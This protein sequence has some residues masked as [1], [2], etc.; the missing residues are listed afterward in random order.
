MAGVTDRPF[1]QLCRKLSAGMVVSEMVAPDSR[2][3]R[4]NRSVKRTDHAGE[5][6]P[7]SVQIVGADPAM[8]AEAA[9]YNQNEARG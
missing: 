8:M 2:L 1:R 5:G 9:R 4:I 7:K 6:E 3:W